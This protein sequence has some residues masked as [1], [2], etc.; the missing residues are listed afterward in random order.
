MNKIKLNKPILFIEFFERLVEFRGKDKAKDIPANTLFYSGKS[1]AKKVRFLDENAREWNDSYERIFGFKDGKPVIKEGF[2]NQLKLDEKTKAVSLVGK[3]YFDVKD[4][5]WYQDKDRIETELKKTIKGKY[6]TTFHT[7]PLPHEFS[8]KKIDKT[9]IIESD[10]PRGNI[11]P[12]EPDKV[13]AYLCH[14]EQYQSTGES[15]IAPNTYLT[16]YVK[17]YGLHKEIEILQKEDFNNINSSDLCL[18]KD[19]NIRDFRKS[20]NRYEF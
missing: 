14:K 5:T 17:N 2:E 12:I 1:L 11:I 13:Y 16:L 18:S 10:F 7:N 9:G 3:E 15:Y 4:L 8:I 19:I 6:G 20:K